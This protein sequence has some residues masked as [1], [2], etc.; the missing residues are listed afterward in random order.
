MR[1][2]DSRAFVFATALV[3]SACATSGGRPAQTEVVDASGFTIT[4]RVRAGS[5]VR[6]DFEQAVHLLQQEQFHAAIALLVEVT[7]AAPQVTMAHI[8]LGIA[9]G[10]VSDLEH[11]EG[12]LKRALE[13]NPRHPAAHNELGILY[14]RMGRFEEAR[15]SYEKALALYPDFH[16]ARRNLAI[17]CDLYLADVSCA[18]EHYGVYIQAVPDDEAAA[19][20]IADLRTRAGR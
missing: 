4:E 6:A 3:V 12:S 9:Y 18:L 10:R 2:L 13:L 1:T 20:W 7:A 17:L 11:A 5:Q 19:I 16:F 8:D 14:R 15:R